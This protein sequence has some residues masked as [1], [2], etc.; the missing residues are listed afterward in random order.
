[1]EAQREQE[2]ARWDFPEYPLLH[3][4]PL[5][6]LATLILNDHVLKQRYPGWVTGKL[7]DVAGMVFF[8]LLLLA[9]I[10]MGRRLVGAAQ[11]RSVPA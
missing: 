5:F 2:Q 11:F 6:A 1:M 4:V 3:P 7:S 8:P 9:F 10:D